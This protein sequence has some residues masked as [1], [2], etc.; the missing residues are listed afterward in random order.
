MRI[1]LFTLSFLIVA[2]MAVSQT[3]PDPVPPIAPTSCPDGYYNCGGQ[4]CCPN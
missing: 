3:T 1:F 4:L 2:N